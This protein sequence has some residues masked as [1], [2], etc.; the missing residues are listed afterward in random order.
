[1]KFTFA[2]NN[3][4]VLDLEKSVAFYREALH[5]V[6]TKRSEHEGFTLVFM[7]DGT[8][9]HQLELTRLKDRTEPYDLG[10]NEIHLA[11]RVDDYTAAHALHEKMACICYENDAMGLYFINDPDGYWIEIL[12]LKR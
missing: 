10:D 5:L 8:S 2:H 7:G 12:P 1:M 11:F 4:N 6:E 9:Q 3:I